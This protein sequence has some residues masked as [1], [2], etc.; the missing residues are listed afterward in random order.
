MG[1]SLKESRAWRLAERDKGEGDY[2]SARRRLLSFASSCHEEALYEEI[3]RL[4][5][6]M[7]DPVEAGKWF[8]LCDCHDPEAAACMERFVAHQ[9]GRVANIVYAMPKQIAERITMRQAP[10]HVYA[11]L[12]ALGCSVPEPRLVKARPTSA[13]RWRQRGVELLG[14]IALL[15]ILA[16]MMVGLVAIARFLYAMVVRIVQ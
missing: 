7:R 2:A 5:L 11:R 10:A 13:W 3:A 8:L 14:W 6:A 4:S 9:R 16:S 1:I 12:A 15:L